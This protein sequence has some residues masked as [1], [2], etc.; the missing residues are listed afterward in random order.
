MS[1][2]YFNPLKRVFLNLS[3]GTV[4]GDTIFE[5]GLSVLNF[6]GTNIYSGGTNLS[7]VITAIANSLFQSG[8]TN[9]PYLPLNGGIGGPYSFTGDTLAESIF[10]SGDSILTGNTTVNLLSA[11]SIN[12]KILLSAS[13][14]LYSIFSTTDTNDIT[15]VQG[16]TNIITGGTNNLPTINIVDS[17]SF[18]SLE[19]SG[20]GKIVEI[21]TSSLSAG[22]IFSATTNLENIIYQISQNTSI[23]SKT[24]VQPGINI[25]TGGTVDNPTINVISNPIFNSLKSINISGDTI[26]SGS[27]DLYSIFSTTDTND[28]TRVQP[29]TN[30]ITGGTNNLP[31]INVSPSPSFNNILFSGFVDGGSGFTYNNSLNKLLIQNLQVGSLLQSGVTSVF[32]NLFLNNSM[33]ISENDILDAGDY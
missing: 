6:S 12:A 11:E 23:V 2:M 31:T 19:I 7:N 27:T 29:G 28:I 15:R 10:I 25:I 17:P 5:Q 13:T 14:D 1:G 24:Y 3:G 30:I 9:L 18:N 21:I 32:G 26:Y 33:V 16:G 22:T 20:T 4:S 8:S